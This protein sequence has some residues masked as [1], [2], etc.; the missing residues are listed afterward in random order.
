MTAGL[1]PVPKARFFD[2]NG[3]PLAGGLVYTYQAGTTT[4]L[5]TYTDS[6]A[7]TANTNPVV[8][9]SSGYANIWLVGLYKIQLTDSNNVQ[10]WIEDN[11]SGSGSGSNY[12]VDSGGANAY[13]ISPSPASSGYVAGQEY[14]VKISA[15]NTGAST[16]N[17][18]GLGVKNITY[19]DGSALASGAMPTGSVVRLIYDG[20]EFQLQNRNATATNFASITLSGA[21]NEAKAPDIASASTTAIGAAAGNYMHVTGTTTITAFDTV[22]AGVRRILKF[23]G[24]LTLTYSSALLLPTNNSII[25]QAGDVATFVSEGSGNWICV[26][27]E[28]VSGLP[29]ISPSMASLVVLT[30]S[31]TWTAPSTA[32]ANT[33][34]RVTCTGPGG[35]SGGCASSQV[36]GSGAGGGVGII[37]GANL[38]TAST[39]YAAVIGTAG[40]V[41]ASGSN[42]ASAGSNTTMAVNGGTQT[43]TAGGPGLGSSSTNS[44]AVGGTGAGITNTLSYQGSAGSSPSLAAAPGGSGGIAYGSAGAGAGGQNSNNTAGTAPG[45]GGGAPGQTAAAGQLGF[46]GEIQIE[47]LSG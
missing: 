28:T 34:W 7:M 3:L 4:P 1:L 38:F 27:Y 22:Q 30:S 6:T 10:Q 26:D 5:A 40:A 21:L 11:I 16:L 36:A 41:G 37:E 9:D 35:S 43:S 17:V 42:P 14:D 25:T 46:R 8:L 23:T 13:V 19:A 12:Y 31:Q 29:L 33:I 44:P 24:S 2:L 39:G 32:T 20:T 47:R 45:A 15:G 18:N